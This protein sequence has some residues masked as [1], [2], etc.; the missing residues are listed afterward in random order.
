MAFPPSTAIPLGFQS[1]ALT[2][3]GW[4]AM[5]DIRAG[6][7]RDERVEMTAGRA[8]LLDHGDCV[9]EAANGPDLR[10]QLSQRMQI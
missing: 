10:K 6:L 1:R 5:L 4:L 9:F 2:P 3:P 8:Y 7:D